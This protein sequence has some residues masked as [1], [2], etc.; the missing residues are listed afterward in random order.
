MP[1]IISLLLPAKAENNGRKNSRTSQKSPDKIM[2]CFK[3]SRGNWDFYHYKRA[4]IQYMTALNE[5]KAD[6]KM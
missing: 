1:L 5:R 4:A 2:Q 6:N 3:S